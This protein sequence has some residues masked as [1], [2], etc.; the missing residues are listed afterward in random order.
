M[1]SP[2]A[3]LKAARRL[4]KHLRVSGRPPSGAIAQ[5][6]AEAEARFLRGESCRAGQHSS[7]QGRHP[8]AETGGKSKSP[9]KEQSSTASGSTSSQ[10][11]RPQP[12][13][14]QPAVDS[15]T[16]QTDWDMAELKIEDEAHE[17]SRG[18]R[19]STTIVQAQARDNDHAV[20]STAAGSRSSA[21]DSSSD[22][23]VEVEETADARSPRGL[24]SATQVRERGEVHVAQSTAAGSRFSAPC[25]N[26]EELVEIEV[27]VD[28][29]ATLTSGQSAGQ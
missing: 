7:L 27:T 6:R 16:N 20:R 25:S 3:K 4:P 13:A 21:P 5:A 18:K 19:E 1:P 28:D 24:A 22:E 17:P 23:L 14:P 26:S 15:D 9:E 10:R 2:S 11:K 12:P 29:E 8:A